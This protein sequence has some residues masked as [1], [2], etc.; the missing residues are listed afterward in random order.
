MYFK[1][2]K[3]NSTFK[4]RVFGFIKGDSKLS[5][6]IRSK[7][8][9]ELSQSSSAALQ[10]GAEKKQ[11]LSQLICCYSAFTEPTSIE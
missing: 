8:S 5:C 11:Y 6:N 4:A 3:Y 1:K 9:T 2:L 7:S 10:T